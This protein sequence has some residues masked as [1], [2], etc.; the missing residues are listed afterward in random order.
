[1]AIHSVVYG[2]TLWRI[3]SMYGVPIPTIKQVNGLVSD[4]LVPGL[5]LYL[6]DLNPPER[7][8]QIRAGDTYWRLALQ[9]QTTI[10]AII[11]ANPGIDPN[12]L[13]IGERIRI[14][15]ILK[16]PMQSLVFIDASDQ[17]PYQDYLREISGS[18][19]YLAIFTYTFNREGALIQ[20]NDETI[21]QTSKQLNIKPLLVISNYE[22]GTFS[23]ELADEV[24]QNTT[25][26]SV[27]IRNLVTA[28][29][30]KGFAGVSIDFEFVPPTRR[31]E[32]TAFLRELKAALGI[33]I[34]QVNAHAK[35]SDLPT[36]RL[37]GF[38]DYRAIGEIVDIV[39]VMTYDYGYSIGP[40]D[41]IAP[42]WWVEQVLMYATG[43]INRRKVMMA[44]ALYGYDWTLPHQE[45]SVAGSLTANNAQNLA[46]ANWSPIQYDLQS[47]S[48]GYR[49]WKNNVEHA[50]WFEDIRSFVAKYKQMEVYN[51][52]GATYWR[53]RYRFPQNWAYLA[54]NIEVIK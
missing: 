49:Y 2:D 42:T 29:N 3:S 54:K 53:L 6:P 24:L 27:L 39:T 22:R 35:S 8:Y 45:G 44:M 15:T 13:R 37:V 50:V 33:R 18:I 20:P 30:T 52:L 41:P 38:L 23:P 5:N 1:M 36:N 25:T 26:R 19:T 31:N 9:F 46:I 40:P 14:P 51:L 28:V 48:P 12:A 32:F 21:L 10:Q 4:A 47:E 7:F 43:Q 16:Y 34:L 11:S 17:S